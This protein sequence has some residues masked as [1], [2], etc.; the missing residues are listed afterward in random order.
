MLVD[1]SKL[2]NCENLFDWGDIHLC[3]ITS[4]DD[5]WS[6]FYE[7]SDYEVMCEES[8]NNTST[9]VFNK[10]LFIESYKYGNLFGLYV[11]ETKDMNKRK[12]YNDNIFC[13]YTYYLLPCFCI[14]KKHVIINIWVHPRIKRHN[15]GSV[16]IE[17]ILKMNQLD[18]TENDDNEYH[19]NEY[20][21]NEV[22]DNEVDDNNTSIKNKTFSKGLTRTISSFFG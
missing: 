16:I 14:R 7:L 21:D 20:D 6:L 10:S 12:A 18:Y 1:K 9:N 17:T 5:F 13:K 3:E 4:G 11:D 15:F 22:D 2:K 19:D 8:N